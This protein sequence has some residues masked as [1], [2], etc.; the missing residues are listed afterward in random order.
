MSRNGGM[1]P[2]QFAKVES[3]LTLTFLASSLAMHI[4]TCLSDIAL[5]QTI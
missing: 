3:K 5:I 2:Q 4:F 1:L